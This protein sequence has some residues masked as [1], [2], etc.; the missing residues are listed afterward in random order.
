MST[1]G[2]ESRPV[3]SERTVLIVFL[4][5]FLA[6]LGIIAAIPVQLP[7]DG[8]EYLCTVA[9]LIATHNLTFEREDALAAARLVSP[10]TFLLDGPYDY[11]TKKN[12][13]T[14]K[15]MWGSHTIYVSLIATP[16]VLLFKAK[17]FLVLNA[18]CFAGMLWILYRHLRDSNALPAALGLAFACILL[19]GVPSYVFWINSEML[20]MLCL[21][22]AMYYGLRFKMYRAV[23][24]LGIATAIKPPLVLVFL[25]L[26]LWHFAR[27]RSVKTVFVMGVL[28]AITLAPHL[29]YDALVLGRFGPIQLT[30][31][32]PE[33]LPEPGGHTSLLRLFRHMTPLR[34]WAFWLGP[35][36]GALWFYPA[37]FWCGYRNRYPRWMAA[38]VL[39]T[40]FA[41]S[42]LCIFPVNLISTGDGIRYAT[43]V[44]PL[45]FFLAGTWKS[46]RLDWALMGVA[47]FL[48]GGLLIDATHSIRTPEWVYAKPLPSMVPAERWGVPIYPELLFHVGQRYPRDI[49]IDYVDDQNMLRNNVVQIMMR[50]AQ[51]GEAVLRLLP[52]PDAETTTVHLGAIG[53]QCLEK[54]VPPGRVTTLFAPLSEEVL[55]KVSYPE[56]RLR[57]K[58]SALT[59]RLRLYFSRMNLFSGTGEL[60]WQERYHGGDLKFLYQVA[61][62]L[63]NVYPSR[64]WIL[65]TVAAEDLADTTAMNPLEIMNVNR[66]DVKVGWASDSFI[67][68][69][70]A[71]R[72]EA[73]V[74]STTGPAAVVMKEAVSVSQPVSEELAAVEVSGFVRFQPEPRNPDDKTPAKG[75][76]ILEWLGADG[77]ALKRD[78]AVAVT[79]QSPS[80]WQYLTKALAIPKNAV[81]A[82]LEFN[83]EGRSATLGLDGLVLSWYKGRWD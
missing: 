80:E 37:I 61:A 49:A 57:S 82:R 59:A 29:L 26:A 63:L 9:S 44:F 43:L 41:I 60:R 14:G 22:G 48:G 47:A 13:W 24:L 70:A 4:F 54:E 20:L 32:A 12:P 39:V 5:V 8:H 25:P 56:W 17:G 68:G 35:G 2:T 76:V 52:V 74:D 36:T 45:F 11:N 28:Y 34:M 16:F 75:A 65:S 10:E 23:V 58:K 31:Q 81:S 79:D 55:K 38:C 53:G 69:R 50:N 73:P 62:Q 67:E 1:E 21:F 27:H 71:L 7:T 46:S 19:S 33:G 64:A 30:G 77:A 42:A 6:L 72:I 18:L 3:L 51:P 15:P 83:I 78:P 66:P 40:A